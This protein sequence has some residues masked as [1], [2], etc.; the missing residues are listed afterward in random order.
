MHQ[1]PGAGSARLHAGAAVKD[2]HYILAQ[3]S[4]LFF[5][6]FAQALAGCHHEHDRYDAPRDTEHSEKSAKLVGPQRPQ[7]IDD[8]IS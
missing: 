3:I 1:A 4:G 2:D 6:A 5:L 8:E 7:N